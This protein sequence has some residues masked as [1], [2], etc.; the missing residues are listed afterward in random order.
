MALAS[1]LCLGAS[2]FVYLET[3]TANLLSPAQNQ[4]FNPGR[5]LFG[6]KINVLAPWR[7]YVF[8]QLLCQQGVRLHEAEQQGST[9]PN[10]NS[11]RLD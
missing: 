3:V 8:V 5:H 1:P 11:I 4:I 6:Y 2:F 9:N 7:V 10:L